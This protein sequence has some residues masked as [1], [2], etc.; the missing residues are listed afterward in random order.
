M[1]IAK[2]ICTYTQ[3][4]GF[5]AVY[6]R[7]MLESLLENFYQ[8]LKFNNILEFEVS[9]TKGYDNLVFLKNNVPVTVFSSKTKNLAQNWPFKLKPNF[10]QEL[11]KEK[12]DLVWNFAILQI[13][14]SVISQ[15]KNLSKKYILIFVPNILNYGTPFHLIYHWLSRTECTHPEQGSIKLR[16]RR[17]LAKFVKDNNLELIESGYV[18][19]PWWPDTAFSIRE[20]K[21]NILHLKPEKIKFNPKDPQKVLEKIYQMS[22]IEKRKVFKPLRPLFAHHIWVLCKL[23]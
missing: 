20:F 23:N 19:M 5:G 1:D 12:Y 10:I 15:M 17:G 6:E 22:F 18:D 13:N 11:P 16:L 7:I 3:E 2:L 8:K 9:C 4:E 21:K 14:P